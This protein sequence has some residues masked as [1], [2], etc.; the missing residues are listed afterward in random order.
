MYEINIENKIKK[1]TVMTYEYDKVLKF[2]EY[3]R[4]LIKIIFEYYLLL[5]LTTIIILY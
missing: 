5:Y 4:T 1:S 2:N 3:L